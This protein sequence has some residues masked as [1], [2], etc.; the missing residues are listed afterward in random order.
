MSASVGY[1]STN[2]VITDNNC[3]DIVQAIAST[4]VGTGHLIANNKFT[5]GGAGASD[6]CFTITNASVEAKLTGNHIDGFNRGI[7]IVSTGDLEF[8]NNT[9]I[10]CGTGFSAQYQTIL[11]SIVS[12]GNSYD[13][14]YPSFWGTLY[15]DSRASFGR[16]M[17]RANVN[18]ATGGIGG[19]AN[20]VW[21]QGDMVFNTSPTA[22][23]SAGWIC[24]TGGTPGTWKTFGAI[25][26]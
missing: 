25:S 2:C 7:Y 17:Y 24:T 14:A 11:S 18:P 6:Y 16:K 26:A 8:V 19:G 23:G 3:I 15:A 1:E 21:E 9:T 10:N 20:C 12:H 5:H 4:L 13:S 22:G